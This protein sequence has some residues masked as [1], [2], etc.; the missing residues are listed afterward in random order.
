MLNYPARLNNFKLNHYRSVAIQRVKKGIWP[1]ALLEK[2]AGLPRR[3]R[4]LAMTLG[5]RRVLD[6]LGCFVGLRP[7]P[8]STRDR[9]CVASCALRAGT[10]FAMTRCRHR[11]RSVAIQWVIWRGILVIVKGGGH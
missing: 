7:I 9:H 4:L 2:G 10:T 6:G 11:E 5:L 1:M 8:R 3:L